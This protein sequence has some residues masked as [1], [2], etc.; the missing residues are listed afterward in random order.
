[1]TSYPKISI[2]TPN[3]NGIKYL[4]NTI[5]S[6][7]NQN[8]P[9]LEYIMM[10]GGSSD[11]SIGIIRKYE[12]HITYWESKPDQG[13]YGALQKGFEKS[14]GEIMGWINSDDLHMTKSLFT[15]AEL[16]S[17]NKEINWIQGYPV[18]IDEN[19]RI[20]FHRP[21]VNSKF[22][23]YLKD[24]TNGNFIQQE[25]TFWTRKLW[26]KAGGYISTKY[27]YAGDFELWI[28]YFHHEHLYVTDAILGAFRMRHDGQMSVINYQ[29]YIRE[30]DQVIDTNYPLLS[31]QEIQFL[32]NVVRCRKFN[33]LLPRFLAFLRVNYYEKKVKHLL[34]TLKF[35]FEKY[36][37]TLKF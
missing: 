5:L 24:Y 13:L 26:E 21:A 29:D 15:I 30:C 7:V 19:S 8:Y 10:D 31:G 14:T 22:A 2:V 17:G 11:G 36:G 12:K 9:N 33:A 37:F 6:I 1:M 35:D 32:K 28:R 27:K 18:V 20:V 16:F 25:S 23:F 34:P 4:E 3:L